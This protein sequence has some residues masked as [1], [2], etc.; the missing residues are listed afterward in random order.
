MIATTGRRPNG[1]NR[2]HGEVA[3]FPPSAGSRSDRRIWDREAA[4]KPPQRDYRAL[5]RPFTGFTESAD[6]EDVVALLRDYH[7]AIGEIIIKY[8]GTLVRGRRC[9][10]GL[11]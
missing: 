10:C 5:L 11:Q 4:R 2:T 7:A 9:D 6:A 1:R 3:A 8:S